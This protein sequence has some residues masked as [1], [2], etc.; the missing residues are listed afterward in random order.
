MA[1]FHPEN[2][3]REPQNPYARLSETRKAISGLTNPLDMVDLPW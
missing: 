3:V 1:E 2:V